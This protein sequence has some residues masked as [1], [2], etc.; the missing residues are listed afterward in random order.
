MAGDKVDVIQ[1][2]KNGNY[3]YGRNYRA[4]YLID[5]YMVDILVI[6]NPDVEFTEVF[7]ISIVQDMINSHAQ[8]ASGYMNMP[9]DPSFVT[10]KKINSYWQELLLCTIFLKQFVHFHNDYILLNQGIIQVDWIPG[11]L[12]AIDAAA[13]KQIHGLDDYV[14]LYY[15]EQ[16]LGKKFL[17]SGYK[18]IIDTDISYLHNHSVS[19]DKSIKRYEKTAQLFKSRYYFCANYEQINFLQRFLMKACIGYGLAG[20]KILYHFYS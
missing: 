20:R 10:N 15:E 7:L 13:Y 1:S 8:A 6:A 12:F 19:I 11:S 3:S 16:I 5:K 2:D 14:F 4:F 17:K 9:S 18:M